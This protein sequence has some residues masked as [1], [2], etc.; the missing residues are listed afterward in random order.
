[1]L[2]APVVAQNKNMLIE[3]C[4]EGFSEVAN[5]RSF[6]EDQQTAWVI[7]KSKPEEKRFP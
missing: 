7:A 3:A 2:T 5:G 4:P 1:M 6:R